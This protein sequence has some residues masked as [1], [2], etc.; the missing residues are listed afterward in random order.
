L[1]VLIKIT[2][3]GWATTFTRGPRLLDRFGVKSSLCE[4]Y[5][6]RQW[7]PGHQKNRGYLYRCPN[8]G[9]AADRTF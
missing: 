1:L 9:L 3:Q 2:L 4:M 8:E 6:S 7:T 5:S